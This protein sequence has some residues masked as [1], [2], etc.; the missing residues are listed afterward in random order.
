MKGNSFVLDLEG[1]AR[2]P[3]PPHAAGSSILGDVARLPLS[4]ANV[5][6]AKP[7]SRDRPRAFPFGPHQLWRLLPG[8]KGST[9]F[10]WH[11]PMF[12]AR[13]FIG[14]RVL[15]EH[16]PQ[17]ALPLALWTTAESSFIPGLSR[18]YF[19]FSSSCTSHPHR[20]FKSSRTFCASRYSSHCSRL[21]QYVQT[22]VRVLP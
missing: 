10:L 8:E 21:I 3:M 20:H 19:S 5:G 13:L 15:V 7:G 6:P 2:W 1:A 18:C 9:C 17:I 4:R 22:S 16:S 12:G 11:P 14:S